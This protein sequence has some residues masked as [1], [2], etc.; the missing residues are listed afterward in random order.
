MCQLKVQAY[1]AGQPHLAQ[2]NRQ[3]GF[4]LGRQTAWE[5]LLTNAY[6]YMH[7]PS[8][9]STDEDGAAKLDLVK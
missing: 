2:L 5:P 8:L 9:A 4:D 7:F 3:V 6:I 1:P